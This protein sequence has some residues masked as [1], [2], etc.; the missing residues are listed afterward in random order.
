MTVLNIVETVKMAFPNL[1]D[2]TILQKIDLIQKDFISAT[3]GIEKIGLLPNPVGSRVWR[4]PNGYIKINSVNY[5]SSD[6]KPL[7]DEDMP[8][9]LKY[10]IEK[11]RLIFYDASA[12]ENVGGIPSNVH[13]ITVDYTT[14]PATISDIANVL[15]LEERFHNAVLNGVLRDFY[16][17]FPIPIIY[18]GQSTVMKD[19]NSITYYS[20]EYEKSKI[21]RIKANNKTDNTGWD[22]ILYDYAGGVEL[23]KRAQILSGLDWE[24]NEVVYWEKLL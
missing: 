11:N 2:S 13:L 19:R 23:P 3:G 21:E 1:T 17:L 16:S 22:I 9:S 6:T 14:L 7:Y 15:E 5:Y 4:I 20:T 18:N 12:E 8:Y 10:K 24:D